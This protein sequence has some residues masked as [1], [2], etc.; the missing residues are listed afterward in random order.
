[1]KKGTAAVNIDVDVTGLR[2]ILLEFAGREV[3]GDWI[4]PRVMGM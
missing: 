3:T 1:M 2:F 4:D